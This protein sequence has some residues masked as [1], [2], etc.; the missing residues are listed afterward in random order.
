MTDTRLRRSSRHPRPSRVVAVVTAVPV[1]AASLAAW[2]R[3]AL[4]R[5]EPG[6][7]ATAAALE[8]LQLRRPGPA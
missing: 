7:P 8:L 5:P 6:R 1:G 4:S 2:L 3:E